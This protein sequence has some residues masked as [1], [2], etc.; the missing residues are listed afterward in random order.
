MNKGNKSWHTGGWAK[1]L[2]VIA[3]NRTNVTAGC[4]IAVTRARYI[5]T[6]RTKVKGGIGKV[7]T[8]GNNETTAL[9]T[10]SSPSRCI[11]MFSFEE[12]LQHHATQARMMISAGLTCTF[13]ENTYVKSALQQL[14]P[15]HR[16][17]YR[18]KLIRLVRCFADESTSEVIIPCIQCQ[19]CLLL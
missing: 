8:W 14:Q 2:E 5:I 13:F 3:D 6:Q 11:T 19:C 10:P 18:L 7:Y 4:T 12:S 16:P 17:L 1:K 15:R 9:G